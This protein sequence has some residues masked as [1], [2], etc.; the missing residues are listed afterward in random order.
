MARGTEKPGAQRGS[1]PLQPTPPTWPCPEKGRRRRCERD[2][3]GSSAR[4]R[5]PDAQRGGA[6]AP[7]PRGGQ[8]LQS[9]HGGNGQS[10][11]RGAPLN[12]AP[13]R[14]TGKGAGRCPWGWVV[15]RRRRERAISESQWSP[16]GSGLA[17]V[18]EL[19]CDS[20]QRVDLTWGAHWPV[21]L[22]TLDCFQNDPCHKSVRVLALSFCPHTSFIPM[23]FLILFRAVY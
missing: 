5:R 7:E 14:G 2:R 22:S 9:L 23:A 18:L 15:A 4:E 8:G 13:G 3:T 12:S 11:Y 6:R 19:G 1:P 10:T 21:L 20:A 17:A 16:G